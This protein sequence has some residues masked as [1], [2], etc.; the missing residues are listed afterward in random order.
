MTS[1]SPLISPGQP[2]VLSAQQ[3]YSEH[4]KQAPMNIAIIDDD[5]LWR[6]TVADLL[7]V[8]SEGSDAKISD[9]A[10]PKS[11]IEQFTNHSSFDLVL[12]DYH[13]PR[14]EFQA[15][16]ALVREV[17]ENAK[18]VVVSADNSPNHII[19]AIDAGAAGFIPKSS[20][21][22]LQ[23]AALR[24]ILDGEI[25]L[26]ADVLRLGADQGL[27]PD[28]E[29]NLE[30]LSDAQR[31]ILDAT[32]TGKSNKVIAIEFGL[33]EGTVANH[34]SVIYR[35]LGVQNRTQ[36]VMMFSQTS[37]KPYH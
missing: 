30:L 8:L 14:T 31:K 27:L 9:A 23:L 22:D 24:H 32:V 33:H 11:A 12:L 20:N 13:I 3:F 16:I 36:A 2:L 35:L 26:P 4:V 5:N 17:F 15:N 6:E 34:L 37:N 28:Q 29:R 10:N 25:Y 19:G 7:L 18:I 21:P 1:I